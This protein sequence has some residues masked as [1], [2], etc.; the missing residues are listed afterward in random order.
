MDKKTDSFPIFQHSQTAKGQP[1]TEIVPTADIETS[2][3]AKNAVKD[4]IAVDKAR[5]RMTY[6]YMV[7]TADEILTAAKTVFPFTFFPSKIIVDR[8]QVNILIGIFFATHDVHSFL[9]RDISNV[10]VTKGLLFSQIRFEVNGYEKNP[11]PINYLKIDE[12]AQI[13]MIIDGIHIAQVSQIDI[14]QLNKQEILT[15]SKKVTYQNNFRNAS[16]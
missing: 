2:K 9:I 3:D 11:P 15:L 13:K 1:P 16:I 7:K 8:N 12:A 10:T 6:E 5:S 4:K 14:G